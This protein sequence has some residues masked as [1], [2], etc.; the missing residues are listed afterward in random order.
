MESSHDLPDRLTQVI[1]DLQADTELDSLSEIGISQSVRMVLRAIGWDTDNRREVKQEHAIGGDR[2]DY[3]LF[4][5]GAEQ[6]FIEVKKGGEPLEDHQEQLLRYAFREDIQ[7]ALLTNGTVWWFYLPRQSGNWEQRRFATISL[8]KQDKAEVVCVLAD[9]L[10]K[11]NVENGYAL[12]YAD[13][14]HR[15]MQRRTQVSETLPE[16]WNQ[17]IDE[18]DGFIVARLAE[19]T[20]ELCKHEPDENEVKA[21]LSTHRE[22]LRITPTPAPPARDLAPDKSPSR[23]G[24]RPSTRLTVTM[25]DGTMINHKNAVDTFVEV[26][27]TIGIQRVKDLKIEV[28]GRDLISTSDDRT[29]ARR[30]V[31]GYHIHLNSNT[32]T[33]RDVLVE[34]IASRLNVRLKVEIVPK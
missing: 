1:A 23:R 9:I 10:S 13:D 22:G 28:H 33:K 7:L 27:R 4:I 17:L 29:V 15:E 26:I 20:E 30:E 24:K 19:K 34:D 21:F 16:A 8:D 2:V 11:E 32:K 14:L 6:M 12:Q 3:A 18:F 25:D 5:D 31:D